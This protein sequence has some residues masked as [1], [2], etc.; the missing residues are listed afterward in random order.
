[1]AVDGGMDPVGIGM[2]EDDA[3]AGLKA[4]RDAVE[5][6]DLRLVDIG[7]ELYIRSE[8]PPTIGQLDGEVA[9]ALRGMPAADVAVLAEE[10]GE[11]GEAIVPIVVAGYGKHFRPFAFRGAAFGKGGGKGGD[12]AAL[13]LMAGGDGIDLIAAE[14]EDVPT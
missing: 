10:A 9:A 8:Q 1:M 4:V 7:G 6:I 14:H 11:G 12:E 3:I 13:V 5:E 2:A